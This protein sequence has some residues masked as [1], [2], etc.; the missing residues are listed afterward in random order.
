M[1]TWPTSIA[2]NANLYVAVNSLQTTLSGTINSLVTTITLASTSG[3]PTAGAVTIDS[4]V[5][6]YTGISG[7]QLTGCTRGSDGTIAASHNS[8]VPVGATIVAQHHNA[9]KDEIIAIETTLFSYK[10][11]TDFG[12]DSTGVADSTAAIN[13]ALAANIPIYAPPGTYLTTGNHTVTTQRLFAAGKGFTTFKRSSGTNPIF[14]MTGAG[15]LE[16]FTIDGNSL[17]GAALVLNGSQYGIVKNIEM[18]NVAGT[19]YALQTLGTCEWLALE[20]LQFDSNYGHIQLNEIYYSSFFRTK[21][22]NNGAGFCINFLTN[23]ITDIKFIDTYMEGGLGICMTVYGIRDIVFDGLR[24]RIN[25]MPAAWWQSIYPT[26]SEVGQVSLLHASIFKAVGSTSFPIF[27]TNTYQFFTSDIHI[28]DSASSAGWSV[29]RDRGTFDFRMQDWEIESTNSWN[30]FDPASDGGAF[31]RADHVSY[32]QGVTGTAVW[33]SQVTPGGVGPSS[34]CSVRGSNL[35]HSI[36][37]THIKGGYIF[38]NISGTLD[39]TNATAPVWMWNVQGTVTDP[40]NVAVISATG[41]MHNVDGSAVSPTYSWST[42]PTTGMWLFSADRIAWSIAGTRVVDLLSTSFG[43]SLP[44]YSTAA[45]SSALEATGSF[46]GGIMG[47]HA[48]NTSNTANSDTLINARVDGTSAGDP[49]F[50][51]QI[52]GGSSWAWGADNSDGDKWKLCLGTDIRSGDALVVDLSGN[53]T[54]TSTSNQLVLGATRTVTITA[55]TPAT[56]SR[57]WTLPDLATSPTFAALE[58]TQTFSGSKTFSAQATFSRARND[59]PGNGGLQLLASSGMDL[60]LDTGNVFNLDLFDGATWTSWLNITQLG[61]ATFTGQLVGK[62]I[63]TTGNAA[64]GYI[65]EIISSSVSN[66][67]VGTN[68]TFYDITSITLTAGDWDISALCTWRPNTGVFS[69]GHMGFE[70]GIATAS[71]TSTTGMSLDANEVIMDFPDSTKFSYGIGMSVPSWR[72]SISTSTTYYL[73]GYIDNYTSGNPQNSG[74]ISARRV[75]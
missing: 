22:F 12:A 19:S 29:I 68:A 57:T 7:P 44:F 15:S 59:T 37:N 21:M 43:T 40:N 60:R 42:S 70:L 5:I 24:A 25:S 38:E 8:G 20:D 27:D 61:V 51:S 26:G 66:T 72:V 2:T 73:K 75:R 9:L 28:Y 13:S 32:T 35:N 39:L 67:N 46:S 33:S 49:Y 23:G 47:I 58:A 62:G 31:T 16:G 14:T 17:G 74:R 10:T 54:I 45:S 30:L 63:A 34:Y 1:S 18:K 53:L 6:F 65:G 55:P 48:E 69:A 41:R 50:L 52:S 64:A 11:L 4:E 71:G 36:R 3:F 56:S